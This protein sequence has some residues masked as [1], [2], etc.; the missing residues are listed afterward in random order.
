MCY[1]TPN[2]FSSSLCLPAN[3]HRPSCPVP[4]SGMYTHRCRHVHTRMHRHT[5]A[6]AHL[7]VPFQGH[8]LSPWYGRPCNTAVD[9]AGPLP[10]ALC[11]RKP[12]LLRRRDWFIASRTTSRG[13]LISFGIIPDT[14]VL[15]QS[16]LCKGVSLFLS[17]LPWVSGPPL[18]FAT[19]TPDLD[20]PPPSP[21]KKKPIPYYMTHF[22][23]ASRSDTLIL[24]LTHKQPKSNLC[25]FPS[26]M[27]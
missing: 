3:V 5:H 22:L 4:H 11:L 10:T 17:H 18:A 15:S 21:P 26:C 23:K 1:I 19:L 24:R 2:C 7:S 14:P 6:Q 12:S 27:S 8:S 16:P 25:L 20:L 9:E 13:H